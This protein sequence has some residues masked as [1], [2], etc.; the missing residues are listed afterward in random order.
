MPQCQRGI[1]EKQKLHS[2]HASINGLYIYMKMQLLFNEDTDIQCHT[3][4]QPRYDTILHIE[5]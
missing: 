1:Y 3:Y 2:C 4:I 5:K